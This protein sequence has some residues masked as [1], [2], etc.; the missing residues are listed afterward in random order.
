MV[1]CPWP[2]ATGPASGSGAGKPPSASARWTS[3]AARQMGER[4]RF[5][6]ELHD[7]VPAAVTQ[8]DADDRADAHGVEDPAGHPHPELLADECVDQL[9]D[10]VRLRDAVPLTLELVVP[11]PELVLGDEFR[12]GR[13]QPAGV[14]QRPRRSFHSSKYRLRSTTSVSRSRVVDGPVGARPREEV[15]A[16][17]VDRAGDT[18]RAGS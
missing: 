15:A 8:L 5:G 1:A 16:V 14:A 11:E 18:P 17:H 10:G 4:C 2:R 9:G 3:V 12:D 6:L 7:D 13:H